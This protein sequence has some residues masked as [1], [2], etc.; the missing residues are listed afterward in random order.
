MKKFALYSTLILT[1][2]GCSQNKQD[3]DKENSEEKEV[4]KTV[5][6]EDGQEV[7]ILSEPVEDDHKENLDNLDDSEFI[8][9][10]IDGK[11]VYLK[12]EIDLS[13]IV[14]PKPE[15]SQ[16]VKLTS[17]GILPM[18]Y[19]NK[20]GVLDAHIKVEEVITETPKDL[21]KAPKDY[22]WLGVS[23]EIETE[24]ATES[25]D[26]VVPT[27]DIYISDN[28]TVIPQTLREYLE[29]ENPVPK[30]MKP[31][32]KITTKEYYLVPKNSQEVQLRMGYG[33]D[34]IYFE[35]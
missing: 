25:D 27:P 34:T 26:V 15:G 8:E 12:P 33:S 3:Q 22:F 28:H 7:E 19:V 5:T 31:G 35:L 6:L 29:D 10:E 2:F 24:E 14:S 23:L 9:T 11:K 30:T 18:P 1:L 13:S 21:P 20:E 16:E 4:V 17:V 32:E